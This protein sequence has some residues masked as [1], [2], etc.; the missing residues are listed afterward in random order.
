MGPHLHC[1]AADPVLSC[2]SRQGL[3]FMFKNTTTVTVEREERVQLYTSCA[4]IF[5][6]I[7]RS[8]RVTLSSQD[9]FFDLKAKAATYISKMTAYQKL[10]KHKFNLKVC[11]WT[12]KCMINVWTSGTRTS[13]CPVPLQLTVYF[14]HTCITKNKCYTVSFVELT[15]LK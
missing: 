9:C 2:R 8:L 15:Y 4:F 1:R 14:L 11:A 6:T 13:S 5:L 12:G 3:S 7:H 10:Q